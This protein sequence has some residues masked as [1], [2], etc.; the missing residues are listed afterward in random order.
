MLFLYFHG[1]VVFKQGGCMETCNITKDEFE[2]LSELAENI[3]NTL[4]VID[5]FVTKQHGIEE[6][7][8]LTPIIK[9]LHKEADLLNAIFI[10]QEK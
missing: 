4:V 8:N 7:C 3:Y 10:E 1:N 2:R 6:L 5:Y 9:N